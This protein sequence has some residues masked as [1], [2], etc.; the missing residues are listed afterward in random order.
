MPQLAKTKKK[1]KKTDMNEV[2][3]LDFKLLSEAQNLFKNMG[4]DYFMN[5]SFKY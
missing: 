1:T 2:F 5:L 3:P 4:A